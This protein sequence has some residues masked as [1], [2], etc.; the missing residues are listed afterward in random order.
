VKIY[1]VAPIEV[2]EEDYGTYPDE[3]RDESNPIRRAVA[4]VQ[5]DLN[6]E[7]L[8]DTIASWENEADKEYKPYAVAFYMGNPDASE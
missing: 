6:T 2:D 3:I 4:M 8:L 1:V 5:H 7:G